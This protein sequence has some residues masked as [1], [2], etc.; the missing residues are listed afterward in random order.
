MT[1]EQI[2][3]RLNDLDLFGTVEP[4]IFRYEHFDCFNDNYLIEIKSRQREYNPWLIEKYK[5]DKNIREATDQKKLFV[6]VTEF[7]R[8]LIIWNI[9]DLTVNGY[10]F[11]WE[12]KRQPQTTEFDLKEQIPKRVGYLLEQFGKI[13][14]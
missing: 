5:Y 9:T 12:I 11:N 3:K 6:Y 8:K 7:R 4:A 1:Q 14:T 10:N 13:V 2:I